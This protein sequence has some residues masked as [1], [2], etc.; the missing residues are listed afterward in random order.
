MM[1]MFLKVMELKMNPHFK[2]ESLNQ[3]HQKNRV[4]NQ[5][6]MMTKNRQRKLQQEHQKEFQNEH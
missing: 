4:R 3:I 1:I 2:K 6:R 5:V